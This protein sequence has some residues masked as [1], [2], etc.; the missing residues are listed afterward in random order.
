MSSSGW[1]ALLLALGAWL[2]ACSSGDSPD[3]GP[4]ARDGLDGEDD[5]GDE[6]AGQQLVFGPPLSVDSQE[7]GA[8][9]AL[10][11]RP[12]GSFA[13]A[14]FRRVAELS[15][16]TNPINGGPPVPVLQDQVRYAFL[17]DDSWT[18]EDVATVETTS[19]V[20]IQLLFYQGG[21]RIAYLGGAE[22][23]QV[24]GGTDLMMASRSGA[25]AWTE[26]A[27]V[28]V[29]NQAPE[30]AY[31]PKPQGMCDFGDVVGLWP[32]MAVAPDGSLGLAWRDIGNGY[33]KESN[34]SADLEWARSTGGGYTFEWVSLGLGAGLYTRMAFDAQSQPAFVTYNGKYGA[35][36]F[37]HRDPGASPPFRPYQRCST[38][39]DCEPGLTC[40]ESTYCHQL[41]HGP[42]AALP[43][44][45]LSLAI[46]PVDGRFL[47]AFFDPVEKN[48]ML[49]HSTD[50][51][52]WSKGRI[53]TDGNTGLSPS[54]VIDPRTRMPGV[55]YY[56]C[57][58]YD[59]SRLVC[60]QGQ[61][62]VRYRYF[63]G[64]YPDELTQQNKWRRVEVSSD[65]N[66]TDGAAVSAA[67]LPDGTVGIAYSYAYVDPVTSQ[68]HSA[69][70]FKQGTWQ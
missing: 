30:G 61:D 63:Q 53:D 68:S 47:V 44:L 57:S 66:A 32:A 29:S 33:E 56:R 46:S 23:L 67:V 37:A 12:E 24:C 20:G 51:F 50:G 45:S 28:T 18:H 9:M 3:G 15:E 13:V 6:I 43:P 64:V 25:G 65:S 60:N 11:A 1:A 55:A 62:G 2:G 14:Y 42:V 69:L 39:A 58:N 54:L 10:A 48:L 36:T 21:P 59:P 52:T 70:M 26:A 38:T 8:Q 40:L 34:D 49:A 7:A 19:L 16:C 41:V 31:C 35:I 22:G 27:A 4:D 5:G 17:Q